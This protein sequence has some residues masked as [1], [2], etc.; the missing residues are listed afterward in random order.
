MIINNNN[1]ITFSKSFIIGNAQKPCFQKNGKWKFWKESGQNRQIFFKIEWTLLHG[2]VDDFKQSKM[3]CL[4]KA[5]MC[6]EMGMFTGSPQVQCYNHYTSLTALWNV[7]KCSRYL[8]KVIIL[9]TIWKLYDENVKNGRMDH[10]FNMQV[11]KD[12][13]KVMHM[14]MHQADISKG[15]IV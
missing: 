12:S 4:L 2:K 5:Y 13:I 9:K 6:N 3:I 8:L 15:S 7:L 1:H 10:M 11:Q 14:T